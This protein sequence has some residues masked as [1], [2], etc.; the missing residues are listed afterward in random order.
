MSFKRPPNPY[1]RK[2]VHIAEN[3]NSP[4]EFPDLFENSSW[5]PPKKPEEKK[6]IGFFS[7][8]CAALVKG[9]YFLLRIG[10]LGNPF[11]W[12]YLVLSYLVKGF[13]YSWMSPWGFLKWIMASRPGVLGLQNPREPERKSSSLGFVGWTCYLLIMAGSMFCYSVLIAETESKVL[14]HYMS[15]SF[16]IFVCGAVHSFHKSSTVLLCASVGVAMVFMLHLNP[17][18]LVP[19]DNSEFRP[20]YMYQWFNRFFDGKH[21]GMNM[22]TPFAIIN[23]LLTKC[24]FQRNSDSCS[25]AFARAEWFRSILNNA[26]Y[27]FLDETNYIGEVY[28]NVPY[29]NHNDQPI[30][31]IMSWSDCKAKYNATDRNDDYS[32]CSLYF[33]QHRYQLGLNVK[34]KLL[35][36]KTTIQPLMNISTSVG[37]MFFEKNSYARESLTLMANAFM[38]WVQCPSSLITGLNMAMS[39]VH[40][41]DTNPVNDLWLKLGNYFED[42]FSKFV[43]EDY[44]TQAVPRVM[45][46]FPLVH[47]PVLPVQ[48]QPEW[49]MY[50][51]PYEKGE[52]VIKHDVAVNMPMISSNRIYKFKEERCPSLEKIKNISWNLRDCK[53]FEIFVMQ[54]I[55]S[56]FDSNYPPNECPKSCKQRYQ[57]TGCLQ[58]TEAII[59]SQVHALD[60]ERESMKAIATAN[61][62]S[63]GAN[64][65]IAIKLASCQSSIEA[66]VNRSKIDQK[67]Y[68][69]LEYNY[70]RFL[71]AA[72]SSLSVIARYFNTRSCHLP[73]LIAFRYLSKP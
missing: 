11:Y 34:D 58:S 23:F 43:Y 49:K 64:L 32:L 52:V 48:Y 2:N 16:P 36:W 33:V 30:D 56:S 29:L 47:Y 59:K 9:M 27:E 6:S 21:Q 42:Y 39:V 69:E 8:L 7:R 65:N 10:R 13:L 57:S 3:A 37:A 38:G 24:S 66:L 73:S 61:N 14:R 26:S 19:Q 20:E 51:I 18:A 70:T 67:R 71:K 40:M 17:N 25:E 31:E 46:D 45:I 15:L 68:N 53:E 55:D 5:T 22:Q 50:T 41:V 35:R 28:V 4:Q 63:Y 1:I 72:F 60:R 62:G 44:T 12:V 54:V